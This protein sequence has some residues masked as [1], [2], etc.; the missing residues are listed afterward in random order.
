[1]QDAFIEFISGLAEPGETALL[2]EQKPILRNGEFQFHGDGSIKYTWPA[3]LPTPRVPEGRAWYMNTGSFII[4]RFQDGKPSAAAANAEYVL[5]MML[6][7]IGTKSK[8][9]PLAPTWVMETSAGSFQWGYAFSEQPTTAEF[10]AA[11]RAIA[12]AGY[13]D[14]GATNAVRNFRIPGSVNLKPGRDRFVSRLVAFQ[15]DRQYTLAQICEALGVTPAAPDTAKMPSVRLTDD[16]GDTVLRWLNDQNLVLSRVNLEGWC[17]IVCPNYAE[18]SDGNIEA[19]Y[20]PLDRSFCCWHAHCEGFDSRAF[21]DWVA[22]QG[23]PTVT[24]G[25]RDDLLAEHM[26]SALAKLAPTEAFPDRAAQIVAEVERKEYGRIEKA[27]W[28]ERFAYVLSDDA[29]FDLEARE[30]IGRGQFNALFRHIDCRSVHDSKRK[31]E[32]SVCFDQNR[33]AHGA[34]VLKGITYAAGEGIIVA[35]PEGIYGNRWKDARPA[36]TGGGDVTPWLDHCRTLVPDPDELEHVW[37][38]MAFKVQNPGVKINHAVL[39]GGD[40]GSGKDTMWAPFLWAICGPTG[41]NKGLVDNEG[42]ASRWG[43]Q[44]ESEVLVLNELKEPEASARRALANKLKPLIAAPPDYIPI[45]RKGLD[46]YNMVNRLLVL[47]FTNDP[48]PISI[49]SQDR[50]WFCLWSSAPRMHPDAALALWS[51]YKAGGYE[52]I[53]GWLHARDVS[54]FNPAAAPPVTEYK[55]SL[56]E[57]GMSTAESYI[58]EMIRGRKGPFAKGVIGSPFHDTCTQLAMAM[59]SGVKV[60]QAALLHGLKEAGWLD[61]GRVSSVEFQTKKHLFCAPELKDYTKSDLRRMVEPTAAPGLHV[62][63]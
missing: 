60:P 11:I 18:H 38:V 3:R 62:V 37:N 34:K 47:A 7:D 51:W 49:P 2:V 12:D 23:G 22:A 56:V 36:V 50:R 29:Y 43:Y 59:P 26:Q 5:V 52:A 25:L 57:S 21:L 10:T 31:V 42:L 20:R 27:G 15:P 1:M 54:A 30:E 45:E 16:G 39:H 48:I 24:P 14:P 8:E 32:A 4:D 53:A 44:L 55:L 6:D 41:Q 28:Y 46:P 9:P 33:E 63:G 13:T 40:E 19:R 17:G 61:R 35:T 58:V